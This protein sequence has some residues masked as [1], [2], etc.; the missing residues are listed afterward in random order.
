MNLFHSLKHVLFPRL[1]G[2][3]KEVDFWQVWFGRRGWKR[4][5]IFERMIDPNSLLNDT[6]SPIVDHINADPVQILDVGAGPVT[7]IGWKHPRKNIKI[8][9]VDALAKQYDRI[10]HVNGIKPI[11]RT[12]KAECE[13][14]TRYVKPHGYHIVHCSNAMDHMK[15]PV[16]AMAEMIK[17]CKPGGY[18]VLVHAENEA[19]EQKYDGLHQWNLYCENGELM[20]RGASDKTPTNLTQRFSH[21]CTWQTTQEARKIVTIGWKT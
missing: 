19:E 14:L 13:H 18:V 12:R 2:L 6:L 9:P 3:E 11:E 17:A 20:L 4:P 15:D 7:A 16:Q 8:R 1:S 5:E 21:E 10:L